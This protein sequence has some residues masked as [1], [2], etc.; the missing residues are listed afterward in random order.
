M[1][2]NNNLSA[3][4]FRKLSKVL[5]NVTDDIERGTKTG[6]PVALS[7]E[8][9]A[10]KCEST[11]EVREDALT[12]EL[13]INAAWSRI[14][15]LARRLKTKATNTTSRNARPKQYTQMTT[16]QSGLE[17]RSGRHIGD[18]RQKV[19]RGDNIGMDKEEAGS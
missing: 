12:R 19:K 11:Q 15:V 3:A 18:G 4:K 6:C 8:A 7:H 14:T 2:D 9:Y 10:K 1:V 5:G 13:F 16:A 17:L